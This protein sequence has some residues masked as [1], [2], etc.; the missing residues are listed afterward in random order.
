M[1][2]AEGAA[3]LDS[4]AGWDVLERDEDAD[5]DE[6]PGPRTPPQAEGHRAATAGEQVR[7]CKGV[8]YCSRMCCGASSICKPSGLHVAG[9]T[10][11]C[12]YA[13]APGQQALTWQLD[14]VISHA[15][16]CLANKMEVG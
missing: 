13:R 7:K 3:G 2:A 5:A 1:G 15:P 14:S 11:A 6:L 8:G 10:H 4:L 12:I 16:H 9:T